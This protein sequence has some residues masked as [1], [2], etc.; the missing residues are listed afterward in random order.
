[1][2][3]DEK[4]RAIY[5]KVRELYRL[6]ERI[7]TTDGN[8]DIQRIRHPYNR[9]YSRLI[10]SSAFRRLQ[11]KMQLLGIDSSSYYRNRLTHSIEV[12][13]IARSL[14]IN[15]ARRYRRKF[16][17]FSDLFLIETISLAHDIGN[18]PFGHAGETVLSEL[19]SEIGGFEG[20][21]QTYRILRRTERKY[22]DIEGL[23][24]TKRTML[25]VVKYC[26]KRVQSDGLFRR[27]TNTK[28][29]YDEDYVEVMSIKREFGIEDRQTIDCQVMDL[30]DEIAYGAHDL[31][32][33]IHQRLISTYDLM[34]MF[35]KEKTSPDV[36]KYFTQEQIGHAIE[37]LRTIIDQSIEYA[38]GCKAG[39]SDDI[40]ETV[41]RKE[42]SARIVDTLINDIDYIEGKHELG[43]VEYGALSLGL[44]RL[45]FNAI[46]ND[47]EKILLY[48]RL[49][50]NV[51]RKLFEIYT[52]DKFNSKNA[53]LSANFR[54]F[55]NSNERKRKV[56]D[57][58]SGMMDAYAIET[59]TQLTGVNPHT[60]IYK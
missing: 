54:V 36:L 10:Y 21:A 38:N 9:D 55:S 17:S 22:R 28:F 48:E 31:E 5:G 34:Y 43:F 39:D 16:W 26:Q 46:K 47:S 32:D 6:E 51:I 2:T 23:N 45:L 40:F 8:I 19:A 3:Q 41:F 50:E 35:Q 59:Y 60:E 12:A 58:I 24:L 18:P 42:V 1:M 37:K 14:C 49:G 44:K 11:G 33:A 30:S 4:A 57:Y 52:D 53:L 20:N 27:T 56:I 25:G 29:L 15:L 7:V 13:Q